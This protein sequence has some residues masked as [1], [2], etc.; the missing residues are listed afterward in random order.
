MVNFYCKIVYINFIFILYIK[1]SLC[2]NSFPFGLP[3]DSFWSVNFGQNLPIGT[4]HHTSLESKHPEVTK[5]LYMLMY[6]I[7][8]NKA[9]E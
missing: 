7:S 1:T 8:F 6:Y 9:C 2:Q 5:N 3:C 4:A